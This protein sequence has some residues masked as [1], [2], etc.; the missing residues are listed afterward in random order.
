MQ[1]LQRYGEMFHIAFSAFLF[2]SGGLSSAQ[3]CQPGFR[4]QGSIT[5]TMWYYQLNSKQSSAMMQSSTAKGN[6]QQRLFLK[7]CYIFDHMR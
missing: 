2:C 6:Y 5:G 4:Y 7:H 1:R 3:P